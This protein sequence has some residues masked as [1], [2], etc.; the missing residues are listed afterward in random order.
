VIRGACEV[1]RSFDGFV[2]AVSTFVDHAGSVDGWF[3]VAAVPLQVANLLVRSFAWRSL[4]AAAFPASTV[5]LRDVFGATTAGD[6]INV[7]APARVGDLATIALAHAE[8]DG[9]N[10]PAVTS[11]LVLLGA[12]D[13]VISVAMYAWVYTLGVF[14]SLPDLPRA[15]TFE[16]SLFASD[17]WPFLVAGALVVVGVLVVRAWV[18]R[19]IQGLWRRTEE[20]VAMLHHPGRYVRTVAFPQAVAV[21]LRIAVVMLALRAFHLPS[22]LRIALIVTAVGSI[23]TIVP[24]TPNGAGARQVMLAYALRHTASAGNVLTFSIGLQVFVSLINGAIGLGSLVFMLRTLRPSRI[25]RATRGAGSDV[26]G[27]DL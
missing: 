12:F 5:R 14:P 10:V 16:W 9:S 8:I 17:W 22:S 3:L 26:A 1:D 19:E 24:L 4:L 25:R 23:T 13:L 7:V 18:T 11:S 20:G 2:A 6:A 27:S 15:P 21:A